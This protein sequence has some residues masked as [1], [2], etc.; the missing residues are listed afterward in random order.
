MPPGLKVSVGVAVSDEGIAD[1]PLTGDAGQLTP[2]AV[3]LMMAQLAWTLRQEPAVEGI[4]VSIDGEPVALPGGVSS[5]RVDGG[6][7]Y[8]PAGFH[9]SPLLYGLQDGRVVSGAASGLVPVDGP[10]GSDGYG[11]RSLG[12]DLT[13][14]AAA[15]VTGGRYVGRGRPPG[16]Q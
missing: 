10:L 9:A 1:I 5:Y 15:G 16:Q 8:D 14:S 4:R 3:E 2:N 6:A 11:L 12:V 7:E 13:A